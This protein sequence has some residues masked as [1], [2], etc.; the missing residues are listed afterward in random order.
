VFAAH[1]LR[2]EFSTSWSG[3]GSVVDLAE[4]AGTPMAATAATEANT[5][6]ALRSC[7]DTFTPLLDYMSK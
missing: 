5:T 7:F 4:A 6:E 2:R 3:T 1:A